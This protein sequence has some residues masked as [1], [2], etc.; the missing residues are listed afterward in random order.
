DHRFRSWKRSHEM[1]AETI[2]QVQFSGSAG[3]D[4]FCRGQSWRIGNWKT[5]LSFK[6][7][8]VFRSDRFPAG[9]HCRIRAHFRASLDRRMSADGHE[10]AFV[11]PNVSFRE[12]EVQYHLHCVRAIN[13]LGEPHAPNEHRVL[14][15]MN[16]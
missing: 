15:A 3:L 14:R 6:L 1:S 12:S 4:H 7:S 2:E 16:E 8:C 9:E 13:M 11:T 5:I 10:T